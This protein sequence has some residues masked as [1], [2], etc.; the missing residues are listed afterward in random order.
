LLCEM[1][2]AVFAVCAAIAAAH[3]AVSFPPPRNAV[4]KVC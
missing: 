4:D 1:K 3:G 2:L